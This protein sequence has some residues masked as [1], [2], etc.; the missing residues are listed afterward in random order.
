M[1][2]V[3]QLDEPPR[4]DMGVDLGGRDIG[5][6]EQHLNGAKIRAALQQMGREGV[7]KDMR[8]DPLRRDSGATSP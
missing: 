6:A 5:V 2:A 1:A 3:H 4:I 8:A 7:A